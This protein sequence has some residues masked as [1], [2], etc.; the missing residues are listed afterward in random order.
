MDI[1]MPV[2]PVEPATRHDASA[3]ISTVIN[4]ALASIP[5]PLTGTAASELP[6]KPQYAHQILSAIISHDT[7]PSIMQMIADAFVVLCPAN[8]VAIFSLSGSQ[9]HLEAEAGLPQRVS[10]GLDCAAVSGSEEKPAWN[11]PPLGQILECGVKLCQASPLLSASGEARGTFTV[12][13][14]QQGLLDD[15]TRE[16][17]GN[18]SDLAR[19]AMEHSQ[20]YQEVIRG[21]QYDRLTGFPNRLVLEDRLRQAMVN[22]MRQGTLLGVC[23]IDLDRFKR[24]NDTLGQEVGDAF[25]KLV[26]ERLKLSIREVD[27]LA[28]YGSDRF[29]LSLRDLAKTSDAA[30]ICRRLLEGL[31]MPFVV[32]GHSLV[33]TASIGIS[34]FPDHGETAD[35]LV[36]NADMALLAAKRAGGNQAQTYSPAL[37]RTTRRASEMVDALVSAVAQSQFRMVYQPIYTMDKEIAGFEALLRWNHPT[38]GQINPLEFIPTAESSGL[39][40]AIGDWVID[41]VCRQAVEWNAVALRPVK[42]FANVSG[43]QLERPDFSSKIADA[44][45]RSGLAPRR[46]E[47]EI[48]ESWIIS[49]LRGA[50]GKLQKLRDLGIGIAIDDFGT[51]NATFNYLQ[52]LPLDTLK[53]DRSFVHRLDGSTAAR[54]TVRAIAMLAQ[55]LGLKTVAEGVECEQHI[56]QL[57]EIGCELMQGFFLARP[58]EPEAACLLLSKEQQASPRLKVAKKRVPAELSPTHRLTG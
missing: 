56:R 22:A 13:D 8:G 49:D 18:L 55:E 50:A 47:L 32:E 7:L 14:R 48:T 36:R 43:V 33:I 5:T 35:L 23:S 16:T 34:I 24:I 11:S 37:G 25:F 4:P 53:I 17:I 31:R 9:F 30:T 19:L 10:E 15:T 51:G 46:L 45:E 26:S 54:S 27:T 44:L 39:I 21:A 52:E 58:L 42:M 6:G 29:V 41:E 57:E 38:W 12:F 2:R 1:A 28:R 20:L 3:G 40:V